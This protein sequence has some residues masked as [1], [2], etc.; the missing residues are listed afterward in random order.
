M[1]QISMVFQ[2]V[3]LFQDTI[4]NNI[5]FGKAD[6]TDEEIEDAARKACCHEFIMKFPNG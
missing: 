3:Y 2:N 1:K 4:K 6:A 5:R